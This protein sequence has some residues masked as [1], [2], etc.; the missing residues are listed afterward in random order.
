MD[1]ASRIIVPLDLPSLDLALAQVDRLARVQ[2]WK[3]GLE[4]FVAVGPAIVQALKQR[5]KRI[6]LDLKLHDIPNTLAGACRS[7]AAHGVDLLTVHAPAGQVALGEAVAAA[8]AGATQAAV[9]PPQIVAVTVLTSISPSALAT[10]LHV[11]LDLQTYALQMAHLAHTCGL[12]GIVCSP[13]EAALMRQHLPPD[14]LLVCPGVR[15]AWAAAN[16]QQRTLTPAAAFQAGASYLVVGRPI[17]QAPDPAAAF[18]R[19]CDECAAV[20][21]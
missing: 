7:A 19:I 21:G 6:F 9:P 8:R 11:A 20:L 13:Q 3:V 5:N 4:L 14:F 10:E 2:F 17:T 16:D 12:S 15:P 1:V 18:Q